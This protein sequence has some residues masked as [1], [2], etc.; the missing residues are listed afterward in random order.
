MR[1]RYTYFKRIPFKIAKMTE[2]FL[3][4]AP[5]HSC[6]KLRLLYSVAAPFEKVPYFYTV[7]LQR[8]EICH[9][10]ILGTYHTHELVKLMLQKLTKL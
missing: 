6:L 5:T 4:T 3:S 1:E 7:E 8:T 9:A 2:T 10:H